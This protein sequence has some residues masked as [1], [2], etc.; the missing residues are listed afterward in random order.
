MIIIV[1]IV[2]CV[3][4]SFCY[5]LYDGHFFEDLFWVLASGVCGL[6][7]GFIVMM[8]AQSCFFNSEFDE[9]LI[10]TVELVALEDNFGL[11]GSAFLF[12]TQIDGELNY[13]YLYN[14]SRGLTTATVDANDSYLRYDT[15]SPRV[16]V[17]E[18][19]HPNGLL[20]W[21]FWPGGTF[22]VIYV[23]EGSIVTNSYNIDLK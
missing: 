23:P 8:C 19:H 20:D 15:E 16:E 21:L 14:S 11:E 10:E 5:W 6:F 1:L 7:V 9:E 22:Y 2:V 18:E 12:S 4:A 3:I 13:T 17:Y